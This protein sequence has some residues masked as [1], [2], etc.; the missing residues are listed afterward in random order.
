MAGNPITFGELINLCL[1]NPGF[2]HQLQENPEQAITA[3]GYVATPMVVESL[4]HFD[5]TAVRKV[6]HACDPTIA[7]VC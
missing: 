5:Y 2:F 1:N 3:A 7:P 4:K 6:F